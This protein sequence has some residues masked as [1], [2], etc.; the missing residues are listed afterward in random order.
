M[1]ACTNNENEIFRLNDKENV[2]GKTFCCAK[3]GCNWDAITGNSFFL[4]LS[5][6]ESFGFKSIFISQFLNVNIFLATQNL[7]ISQIVTTTTTATTTTT[8]STN[9]S[10]TSGTASSQFNSTTSNSNSTTE[11]N[12]DSSN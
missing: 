9:N 5:N 7:N 11:T 8:L 4:T 1:R 10:S 2:Q 3:D 6:F 12:N